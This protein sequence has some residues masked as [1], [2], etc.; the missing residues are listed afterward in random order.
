MYVCMQ[1]DS[2][3][4]EAEWFY[5][6]SWP[7]LLVSHSFS[8]LLLSTL[9]RINTA[10]YAINKMQLL[11]HKSYIDGSALVRRGDWLFGSGLLPPC[12]RT[13]ARWRPASVIAEHAI[14]RSLSLPQLLGVCYTSGWKSCCIVCVFVEVPHPLYQLSQL[15]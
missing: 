7:L 4:R 13:T 15:L 3:L 12:L 5:F 6:R 1:G 9:R 8:L 14:P 10:S 2:L 11:R